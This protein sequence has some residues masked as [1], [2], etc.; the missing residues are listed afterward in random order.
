MAFAMMVN[1]CLAQEN[2]T[3][4]TS[5][6]EQ[7]TALEDVIVPLDLTKNG[8]EITLSG[9]DQE[10]VLQKWQHLII[11]INGEA[12]SRYSLN[13]GIPMN[14]PLAKAPVPSIYYTLRNP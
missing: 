7:Q 8:Y 3:S 4:T 13:Y 6:S 11:K 14:C 10:V 12:V 5:Q 2:T 9:E 1:F